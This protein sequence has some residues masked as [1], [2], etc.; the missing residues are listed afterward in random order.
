MGR[1]PTGPDG[2]RVQ[3][4]P[5]ITLRL[6]PTTLDLLQATAEVTG[7]AAWRIADAAIES[8]LAGMPA[9]TRR[10]AAKL[11]VSRGQQLTVRQHRALRSITKKPKGGS[12]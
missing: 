6:R 12:R 3:D 4:L 5:R 1:P 2:A 10:A 11:V 9:E 7:V 8:R